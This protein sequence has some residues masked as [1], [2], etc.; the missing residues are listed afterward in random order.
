MHCCCCMDHITAYG[1]SRDYESMS[2][3][4][5]VNIIR[6]LDNQL[7]INIGDG[8]TAGHRQH[9]PVGPI[10][11]ERE[12]CSIS[13]PAVRHRITMK[14]A[15]RPPP[16]TPPIYR[17][18]LPTRPGRNAQSKLFKVLHVNSGFARQL[19]GP[20]VALCEKTQRHWRSL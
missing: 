14:Y 11:C 5:K 2:L 1:S 15:P 4:L 19:Y 9:D 6:G 8:L 17:K 3:A 12:S 10:H 18:P 13:S 16:L 7:E 20:I